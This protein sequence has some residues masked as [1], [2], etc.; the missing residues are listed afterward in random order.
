MLC[1]IIWVPDGRYLRSKENRRSSCRE[2]IPANLGAKH[3]PPIS[4]CARLT[5]P[6]PCSTLANGV[7]KRR[8]E[9]VRLE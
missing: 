5:Q 4:T 8:D 7:N 9:R 3:R 1:I 6:A 2:V